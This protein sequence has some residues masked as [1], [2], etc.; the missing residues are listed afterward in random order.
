ML[1]S[2]IVCKSTDVSEEPADS[3]V[4][5]DVDPDFGGFPTILQWSVSDVSV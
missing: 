3:V 1:S 5:V 2:H 4:R